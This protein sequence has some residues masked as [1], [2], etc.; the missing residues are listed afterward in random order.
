M[1]FS[2]DKNLLVSGISIASRTVAQKSS[3]PALEGIYVRAGMSSTS[4]GYN[5]ETGITV[6]VSAD[7]AETGHVRHARP[8]LLDIIRKL[9]DDEVTISVDS[10]FKVFIKSGIASFTISAMSAEDYPELP[11]VEYENA[12]KIPQNKLREMISGTIFS[13][14]ENM[15]RPCRRAAN[16][17]GAQQRDHGGRGRLP[18]GAKALFTPRR[19]STGTSNS[20]CPRPALKE[21]EKILGE[22]DDPAAF[23]LGRKHILFE[24]WRGNPGL[25]HP[26][27]RI[28][29]LA[30]GWCRITTPILIGAN[31]RGSRRPSTG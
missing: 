22:T 27:G 14:S 7:I 23:T 21:L 20:W 16:R 30:P 8:A 13:V 12:I 26:R 24:D 9:P 18:P 25:P 31:R 3:I 10:Q 5:L 6:T 2:C 29:G 17:S 28:F 15:A 11:D 4:S 19:A 1:K